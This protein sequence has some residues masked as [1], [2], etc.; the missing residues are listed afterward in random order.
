MTVLK[1][2]QFMDM[3]EF[4]DTDIKIIIKAP[5][6]LKELEERINV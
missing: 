6:V 3:I 5:F 1:L 4:I 2:T